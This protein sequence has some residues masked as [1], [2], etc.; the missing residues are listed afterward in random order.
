MKSFSHSSNTVPGG[1]SNTWNWNQGSQWNQRSQWNRGPNW[2]RGNHWNQG[3][4]N[5]G[6]D[7]FG[8]QWGN[9]WGN[10]WNNGAQ[11]WA[12]KM[13]IDNERAAQD[14]RTKIQ[15]EVRQNLDRAFSQAFF[16]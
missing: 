11:D 13:R 5:R 1:N 14:L 10:T 3:D 12:N 15:N 16:R 2:N 9:Q 8:N 4:W 6:G 7:M